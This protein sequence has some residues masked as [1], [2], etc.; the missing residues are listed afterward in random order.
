VNIPE[1]LRYARERT[2][3]TG[4]KVQEL[5]GIGQSSLSEF[6]NGRREPSLAQ[7]QRLAAAYRRSLSFFLEDGPI[8][9]EQV[10]WRE[11]PET[12]AADVEAHFLRL[13]ERYHNLEI[14]TGE[15]IPVCL[16]QAS[17]RA[18]GYGY[19]EAEALAK[20]VR[21][22]LE[23]GDWPGHSLLP[24]LEEVCGVK[25]FHLEFEPTGTAASAKSD[26]FGAAVLLND[27]NARWRRN[28][29]LAHE[30]FH[31]LTWDIFR[32]PV[33]N[34]ATSSCATET[35][36]KLAQCFAVNV[37][38]PS[39]AVRA[40][41]NRKVK[42]SGLP[43]EGLFDVARQ[44]DVSVEA[45]LWRMHNLHM[46]SENADETKALIERAKSLSS[47]LEEREQTRP[48]TW[49]ERYKALA[50][51]ALRHGA[52]SVGRFAEYLDTSRQKAMTYVGQGTAEDEAIPLTPA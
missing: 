36:E 29:D 34:G 43:F 25:V 10:L 18:E 38:M 41:L 7:L 28:F 21:D 44:F 49:P 4:P 6:E 26:T 13:C 23:L 47:V 51:K 14:W 33:T 2:G 35:E 50:I 39:D 37:L 42:D 8:P 19:P 31:L 5:T 17:G 48:E 24:V 22:S 20:R 30:L 16:P 40:A 1:R 3:L 11:K 52:I 12:A 32:G 45:L 27:A 46:L 15:E 9:Q